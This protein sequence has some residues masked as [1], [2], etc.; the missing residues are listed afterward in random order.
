MKQF[1]TSFFVVAFALLTNTA[2]I[3][4]QEKVTISGYLPPLKSYD[5]EL[6]PNYTLC[7]GPWVR[8]INESDDEPV[9]ADVWHCKSRDHSCYRF[10]GEARGYGCSG[11][12][13]NG[14]GLPASTATTGDLRAEIMQNVV[15][16]CYLAIAQ[17]HD[18]G[19]LSIEEFAA[20]AKMAN[21]VP[22]DGMVEA[23]STLL[24]DDQ[25][26]EQRAFIFQIARQTCIN[27]GLGN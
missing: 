22:I 3:A 16:P 7:P 15:D 4:S 14:W 5:D 8:M 23:V 6:G 20:L 17:R 1:L 19:G 26:K 13:K 11:G 25:T 24:T 18:S 9:Y 10:H 27:A 12:K 21:P 2:A